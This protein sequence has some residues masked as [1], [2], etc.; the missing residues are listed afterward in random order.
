MPLVSL[1][2]DGTLA[3]YKGWQGHAVIGDPIPGALELVQA[4]QRQGCKLVIHT[5]RM[6]LQV[7][8]TDPWPMEQRKQRITQWLV[9]HGFGPIPIWDKPGKPLADVYLEDRAVVPVCSPHGWMYVAETLGQIDR[10]IKQ[11]VVVPPEVSYDVNP[12]E[13][14]QR[15]AR[16]DQ[17]DG[18]GQ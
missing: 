18:P 11:G 12:A 8:D 5:C 9:E 15:D 2:L 1:D 13:E 3:H 17:A 14:E 4:L 10:V 7:W 16:G 6:T